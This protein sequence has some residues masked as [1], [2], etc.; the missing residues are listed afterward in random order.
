MTWKLHE[1][2]ARLDIDDK[3]GEGPETITIKV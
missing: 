3:N 1:D 2:K